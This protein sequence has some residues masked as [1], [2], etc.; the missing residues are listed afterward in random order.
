MST[1]EKTDSPTLRRH[2]RV[3][4]GHLHQHGAET[5]GPARPGHGSK[6]HVDADDPIKPNQRVVRHSH[7]QSW[8]FFPVPELKDQ[9][10]LRCEARE[11]HVKVE[12][13]I[14]ACVLCST[15]AWAQSSGENSVANSTAS[16][17]QKDDISVRRL[18]VSEMLELV[19]NLDEGRMAILRRL[20]GDRRRRH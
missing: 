15:P 9:R 20:D 19:T 8:N 16:V 17:S 4:P 1:G 13:F 11:T 3:H 12:P 5:G 18:D 7:R 2:G 10:K 6:R 14:V